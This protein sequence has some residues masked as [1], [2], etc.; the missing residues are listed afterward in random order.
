MKDATMQPQ[1]N[2]RTASKPPPQETTSQ[3]IPNHGMTICEKKKAKKQH[4]SWKCATRAKQRASDN[5]ARQ[6]DSQDGSVFAPPSTPSANTKVQSFRF[7]S[8][9]SK[10]H[11]EPLEAASSKVL[12]TEPNPPAQRE[13]YYGSQKGLC[14]YFIFTHGLEC[15]TH[16]TRCNGFRDPRASL[17][18]AGLRA[19]SMSVRGREGQEGEMVRRK[20]VG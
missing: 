2:T 1:H 18:N 8:S 20:S 11:T 10:G 5:N 12:H 13:L 15:E 17:R 19:R 4:K 3:T 6:S 7:G 9:S 16:G 14:E